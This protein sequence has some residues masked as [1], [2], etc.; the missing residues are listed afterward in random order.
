M[1]LLG[2]VLLALL[3]PAPALAAPEDVACVGVARA[4][5]TVTTDTL[6]DALATEAHLVVLGPGP[7]SGDFATSAPVEL[8][9]TDGTV[10]RAD[11]AL[12]LTDAGA[13]HNLRIEGR[14]ETAGNLTLDDVDLGRLAITGVDVTGRGVTITGD[15]ELDGGSLALTSSLVAAADPFTVAGDAT[16]T[17]S[18]SA[19]AADDDADAADRSDPPD[20]P[21]ALAAPAL[22]DR[23]DPAPLQPFEPFEDAAGYPRIAGGRRDIGAYETQPSPVPM[24]PSSVLVNGGAEDGLAGWSGTFAAATYGDPF[25]PTALAGRSL[26]GGARFFAGADDATPQLSQRVDVAA[27]A[28]SIDGG[29]GTA[30][31]SGLLGGYGADPDALSVRAVFKDPENTEL[32]SL[33]LG[34]VGAA[35]RSNGTNLLR[36]EAGGAIPPRTRAIDVL[37]S[38]TRAAGG[39]TDA[40]A[41]NL[42]LVLSVPGVPAKGGIEDPPVLDLKPFSGVGVFTAE[43]RVSSKGGLRILLG[44]T[45]STVGAC[46]GSLQ[47]DATLPGRAAPVRIARFALFKLK[48]GASRRVVMRLLSRYRKRILKLRQL[49]ATLRPVTTDGQGLLRRPRVPVTLQIG[50][51]PPRR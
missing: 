50:T 40:Y 1:V 22:V 6:Q 44:C 20:D 48:P 49:A 19:H 4:D 23:G 21:R 24:S 13:I 39:Y 36:R 11:P 18:F 26:G 9:G 17:T 29:L 34:A 32:G 51:R 16:V 41:D 47:L 38:G 31:L 8:A 33:D 37:L 45:S 12:T 25:L 5:C 35:E 10:I 2:I 7:F 42:S 15:A 43:P 14:L 46:T 28:E 27:A 30:T 3:L